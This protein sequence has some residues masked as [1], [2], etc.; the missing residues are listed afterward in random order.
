MDLIAVADT[1]T[2]IRAFIFA[3]TAADD[4]ADIEFRVGTVEGTPAIA[5]AIDD[6]IHAF[7][8]AEARRL[9]DVFEKTLNEFSH[10]PETAGLSNLIMGIRY[11][12]AQSEDI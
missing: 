6:D 4:D 3:Y 7:T 11:A 5:I 2:R 1:M 10:Q 8:A 12:A 9:A